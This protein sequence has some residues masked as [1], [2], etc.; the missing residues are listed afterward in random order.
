MS[1]SGKRKRSKM[2][3][4]RLAI[5]GMADCLS[6]DP[7]YT[8]CPLQHCQAPVPPPPKSSGKPTKVARV[9]RLH[10]Q[11]E[12]TLDPKTGSSPAQ[13]TASEDYNDRFRQC[14][15]CQFSFCRYCNN[16]WHGTAACPL[17]S[18]TSF[19]QKYMASEGAERLGFERRYG[20]KQ[21]ARMVEEWEEQ[22]A[23][24]DWFDKFTR[25]CPGCQT[26]VNKS[27]GCNH[28][29]CSKCQAHF[30][31]RCGTKVS[32]Q[33]LSRVPGGSFLD[34]CDRRIHIIII[35]RQVHRAL[36]SSLTL[37][38]LLDSSERQREAARISGWSRIG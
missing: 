35:E 36:K 1:G 6:L 24:K 16:T 4:P 20:R 23:N 33:M 30:C 3:S 8:L 37:T 25:A 32:L 9:F 26:R 7:T 21:L 13:I 19:L 14:P 27:A 10:A 28:M 12:P 17:P 11:Q 18:T 38:R 31:Y 2:V 22:Q 15:S 5:R 29:T 34:S